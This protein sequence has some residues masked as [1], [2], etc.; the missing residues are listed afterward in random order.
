METNRVIVISG[1]TGATGWQAAKMFAAQGASLALLSKNQDK[2]NVMARDLDLPPGRLLT[3]VVDLLDETALQERAEAVIAKFGRVDVLIHLVGGWTGGATLTESRL[4]ELKAML[5]QH[6][7]TTYHLIRAFLP[8]MRSNNWG[9]VI[10]V[11]S[12]F[13]NNP[14]A[15]LGPY[16]AGKAA[17]EALLLTLADQFKGTGFTSNIIQ[18][19]SIDLKGEGKGTSPEEIVSA[20]L[21]LCSQEAGK[22]NGIRIP[23]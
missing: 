11:S 19:K 18:V 16:A 1:A 9:R 17:Q 15:Q 5:D 7:W 21:Y 14:S 6:T 2:L 8:V 13:A 22:I 4:E 23:M 20:M 3:Q 12:T 10:A